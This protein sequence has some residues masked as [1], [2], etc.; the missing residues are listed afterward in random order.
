[1]DGEGRVMALDIG[2]VRTGV[3][4]SDPLRI[5]AS[6]HGVV[7]EPT[8]EATVAAIRALV[9]ELRP[10]VV[11]A[12]VPLDR[13]G[14]PGPQAEK[15][16]AM[17]ARLREALDVPVETQDERFSTAAANRSLLAANLR[18]KKRKQV[19]DKVAA[20]HILEAYLQRQ[21]SGRGHE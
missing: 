20:T 13:E 1:M 12:G 5:I 2:D 7:Q 8:P 19:V 15:T 10:V 3:A 4:V 18:R 16:L 21:A 17:V 11:V 6:P 9:E 14:K